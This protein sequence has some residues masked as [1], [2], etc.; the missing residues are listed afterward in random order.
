M[1]ALAKEVA[2]GKLRPEDIT[3][4]R[5]SQRLYTFE[6]PDP[7]FVIR[8]GGDQR[9]SNFLL[10][11]SAYAELYFTEKCWPDFGVEDLQEAIAVYASRERRFGKV[12]SLNESRA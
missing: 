12:Q 2:A 10:W 3:E 11:Q 9:I 5:I 6:S 7:D 8:T 1:Q 4:E